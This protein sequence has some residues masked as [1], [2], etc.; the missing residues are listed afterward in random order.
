MHFSVYRL[1]GLGRGRRL[2]STVNGKLKGLM[3]LVFLSLAIVIARARPKEPAE[4]RSSLTS[5]S[6]R[7]KT[8]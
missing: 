8:L 2:I 7:E 6:F 5:K 1:M 4:S 3:G